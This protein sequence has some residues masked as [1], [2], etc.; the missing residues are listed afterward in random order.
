MWL[1]TRLNLKADSDWQR[2]L[3]VATIAC[4]QLVFWLGSK[5]LATRCNPTQQSLGEVVDITLG[6][7]NR[8]SV[9][10]LVVQADGQVCRSNLVALG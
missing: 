8:Q 5:L 3:M 2:S 1:A 10:S 9:R 7:G 6:W 4:A